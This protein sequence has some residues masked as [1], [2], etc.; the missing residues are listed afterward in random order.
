[1][2]SWQFVG[3][4]FCS[5]FFVCPILRCSFSNIARKKVSVIFF[6]FSFWRLSAR[7]S[8]SSIICYLFE[9]GLGRRIIRKRK[10]SF[11]LWSKKMPPCTSL[12]VLYLNQVIRFW[13]VSNELLLN[14][15]TH[16]TQWHFQK[17]YVKVIKMEQKISK[18][19]SYD[20]CALGLRNSFMNFSQP[21]TILSSWQLN[22]ILMKAVKW[23]SLMLS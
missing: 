21:N 14:N 1:M 3:S 15:L 8:H 23:S 18:E 7:G 13:N 10:Q 20:I 11:Y 17:G 22:Y 4:N 19:F 12:K 6:H 5:I 16:A 9:L 2:A